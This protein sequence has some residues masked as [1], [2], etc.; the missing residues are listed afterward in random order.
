[1]ET[2]FEFLQLLEVI[3]NMQVLPRSKR[4]LFLWFR[5]FFAEGNNPKEK[6]V[7]PAHSNPK[8]H[9]VTAVRKTSFYKTLSC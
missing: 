7:I 5:K 3:T 1:M 8:S 2:A 9:L 4:I 6:L